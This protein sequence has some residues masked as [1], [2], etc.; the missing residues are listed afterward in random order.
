M[1]ATIHIAPGYEALRPFLE[2]LA[3]HGVPD[4]AQLV[5]RSTRNGNY[6]VARN[7]IQ[8]NIK[9]FKL[10]S[11]PNDWVYTTLRPSKAR[12]SYEHALLLTANGFKT[13]E[14]IAFVE[15]KEGGRLRHSYYVSRQLDFVCDMRL[16]ADN[17]RAMAAVPDVAA[18]L[19]R[20]HRAGI[21][22]KDFSPGNILIADRL[23]ADGK[24]DGGNEYY[25][26]DLNR[27]E[28]GVRDTAKMLGN[29][30]AVYIENAD[31]TARFGGLYALAMGR[32]R[33]WGEAEGRRQL[34]LYL[35]R[36]AK[37][38]KLKSLFR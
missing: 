7:G 31:E 27:M 12:R 25:L 37:N 6:T 11:F 32:D 36:K 20:L 1:K 30:G 34:Q 18:L 3:H 21:W 35:D 38:K 17:P 22:H 10:P 9:D 4:D 8:L 13:P 26:I 24:P 5:Y 19:A 29:L 14:P 23:G 33:A 28:F 15:C 16:W 2:Q